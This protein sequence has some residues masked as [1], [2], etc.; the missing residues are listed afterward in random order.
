MV[1]G[2]DCGLLYCGSNIRVGKG[3]DVHNCVMRRQF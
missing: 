3:V 1:A 2:I